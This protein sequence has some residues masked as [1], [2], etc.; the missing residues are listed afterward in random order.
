MAALVTFNYKFLLQRKGITGQVD[1]TTRFEGKKYANSLSFKPR[2]TTHG[3]LY[4]WKINIGASSSISRNCDAI[5]GNVL[6]GH[7]VGN[8]LCLMTARSSQLK[9]QTHRRNLP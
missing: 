6:T 9:T 2:T 4:A 8:A 3:W 5:R 1:I 7:R